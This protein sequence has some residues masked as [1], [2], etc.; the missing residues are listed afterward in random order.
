MAVPKGIERGAPV[1]VQR[2]VGAAW[3]PASYYEPAKKHRGW[4]TAKLPRSA[5][6]RMV[7]LRLGPSVPPE[8]SWFVYVPSQRIRV[9]MGKPVPGQ[10]PRS[11]PW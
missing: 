7:D 9:R 2:D 5:A 11:T 3:E 10:R 6:P 4:H 8:P 1:E